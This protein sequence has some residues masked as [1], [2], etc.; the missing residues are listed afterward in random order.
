ML[1]FTH[2]TMCGVGIRS[3]TTRALDT[4][5][6]LPTKGATIQCDTRT[7]DSVSLELFSLCSTYYAAAC[8]TIP[9]RQPLVTSSQPIDEH[10]PWR[11][12]IQIHVAPL[13]SMMSLIVRAC[14]VSSTRQSQRSITPP[15][16]CVSVHVRVRVRARA[17][18]RVCE[19]RVIKRCH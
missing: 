4:V 16:T 5:N 1:L 3:T 18:E 19:G 17:R 14:H 10:N 11:W 6:S 9:R 12:A 13:I 2:A 7:C 8:R 15:C